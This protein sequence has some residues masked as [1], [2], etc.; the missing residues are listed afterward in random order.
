MTQVARMAF[1]QEG[2]LLATLSQADGDIRQ[3][4]IIDLPTAKFETIWSRDDTS[5]SDDPSKTYRVYGD[6]HNTNM[7]VENQKLSETTFDLSIQEHRQVQRLKATIGWQTRRWPL[8][9]RFL[10]TESDYPGEILKATLYVP[11][12]RTHLSDYRFTP[13]GRFLLAGFGDRFSLSGSI[14]VWDLSDIPETRP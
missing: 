11:P 8:K 6:Y 2:N 4:S 9:H 5:T 1:N 7:T 13:D 10:I 12:W 3:V 14:M